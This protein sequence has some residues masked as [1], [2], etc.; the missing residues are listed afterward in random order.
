MDRKNNGISG[1]SIAGLIISILPVLVFLCFRLLFVLCEGYIVSIY[2]LLV[3]SLFLPF[4]ALALSIAGVIIAKRKGKTG[5]VPG[6][7]GIIIS[8]VEILI[9]TCLGIILF[10]IFRDYSFVPPETIPMHSSAETS[11]S[12]TT[13]ALEVFTITLN[14]D[15]S[16]TRDEH[17]GYRALTWH[18]EQDGEQL[19]RRWA[20]DELTLDPY[21]VRKVGKPGKKRVY[22]V[23]G[24][25]GGYVRVSNIIESDFISQDSE[26]HST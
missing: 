10:N 21:Y 4:I 6:V 22:L 23:A 12:G 17:D 1:L 14:D 15:C 8:A 11:A 25:D 9:I 16:I 20:E 19:L 5:L 2:Y 26:T 7:A 3:L 18:I 24:F 13:T